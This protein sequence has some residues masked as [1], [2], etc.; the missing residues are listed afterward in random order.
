MK[1]S[2]EKGLASHFS[3]SIRVDFQIKFGS[4]DIVIITTLWRYINW[5]FGGILL[6]FVMYTRSYSTIFFSYSDIVGTIYVIGIGI[7]RLLAWFGT[8]GLFGW[9]TIPDLTDFIEMTIFLFLFS[10]KIFLTLTSA[11]VCLCLL[12]ALA[13]RRYPPRDLDSASLGSMLSQEHIHWRHLEPHIEQEPTLQWQTCSLWA[14][15]NRCE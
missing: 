14:L 15:R 5:S 13:C 7:I 1:P 4:R 8:V 3:I 6:L 9:N 12:I 11:A 10:F 2:V